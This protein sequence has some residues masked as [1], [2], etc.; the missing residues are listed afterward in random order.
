ML[1]NGAELTFERLRIFEGGAF[2]EASTPDA[3]RRYLNQAHCVCAAAGLGTETEVEWEMKLSVTTQTSRPASLWVGTTCNDDVNRVNTCRQVN[4]ISDIDRLATA[5]EFFKWNLSDLINGVSTTNSCASGN[6]KA[7]AW[8]LVDSSGDGTP[9][10]ITSKELGAGDVTKI[11][12]TPPPMPT[13]FVAESAEGGVRISWSVP[14]SNMNDIFHY[15]ALCVGPDGL[16]VKSSPDA[17]KYQTAASLCE[18]TTTIDL[19]AS[20]IDSD[21]EAVT[22]P[23]ELATLDSA[24]ICGTSSEATADGMLID[25]LKNNTPYKI[26]LLVVDNYGNVAGTYFDK[27]VTPQPATDFWED[28]HDRG[29]DVEGGF[30]LLAETYGNNSPLTNLLRAFRD[31]TLG[32]SGGAMSRAYYATLGKLGGLVRGS[33]ALR[34]IAAVVL[35][36]LVALALAWHFLSL[37]GLLALI[38]LVWLWRKRRMLVLARLAPAAIAAC[39]V[40]A[41]TAA[42]AQA[43]APYWDGT[44][45][46][47]SVEIDD[48]DL[49]TWHVGVRVGPYSPD[50]DEQFG[51]TPGPYADMFGGDRYTPMIDIDRILWTGFGQFG[52]G[53]SIGYMQKTAKAWADGS[54]PGDPMRMRSPGDENT[55]R[56]LPLALTATYRLTWFD[57]EFGVPI[58]PYV[59]GGLAYYMW[60]VRTNGKTAAACWDGTHTQGCDADDGLGASLGVVG[61]IGIAIRAERIDAAAA[62]SMKQGGIQHA[63][64]YGELSMAKVDGFGSSTK[65]SVGDA[66]WF[67]GVDFE[68]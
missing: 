55:F 32:G 1:P 58:V 25:G 3:L 9:D 57:E 22:L 17:P 51:M 27:T 47:E 12:I 35:F 13:N 38:A 45:N 26:V 21:G 49:V 64:F 20:P 10:Y 8:V 44:N 24:F 42:S 5:P 19:P 40:M 37:P 53:G 63:G 60:W 15:Q 33:L 65:L 50:I 34:V 41:P 16:A 2:K 43:P 39:A 66:T 11:D 14:T 36:P 28:L 59:R 61:S 4:S 31:N 7:A 67:A 23:P 48:K 18:A 54:V 62:S 56:L 29:S 30:C 46:D 68:F 52:V 6:E